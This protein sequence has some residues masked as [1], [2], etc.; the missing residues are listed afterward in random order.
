M[1]SRDFL[2]EECQALPLQAATSKSQNSSAP[3]EE[4]NPAELAEPKLGKNLQSKNWFLTFPRVT[5]TKE[6]ALAQLR[7]KFKDALKGVLIAQ[8]L[9][10]D[11][12]C[13]PWRST[14]TISSWAARDKVETWS[15]EYH[16]SANTHVL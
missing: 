16:C 6:E 12:E 2:V 8:E 14:T 11:G 3:A 15:L 1:D 4:F 7:A 5:T 13:S 10:K 9:H